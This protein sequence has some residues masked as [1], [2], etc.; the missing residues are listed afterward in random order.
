MTNWR[1]QGMVG[2]PQQPWE[3]RH[4]TIRVICVACL[5]TSHITLY[6]LTSEYREMVGKETCIHCKVAGKLSTSDLSK[7]RLKKDTTLQMTLDWQG[8]YDKDI[9]TNRRRTGR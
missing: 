1:R 9:I 8:N 7:T 3:K 4:R 5:K 6:G 2:E